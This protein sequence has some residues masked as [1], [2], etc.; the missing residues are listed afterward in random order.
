MNEALEALA[1]YEQEKWHEQHPISIH[2]D[3]RVAIDG[4]EASTPREIAMAWI[5]LRLHAQG[6]SLKAEGLALKAEIKTLKELKELKKT[7]KTP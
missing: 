4:I 3:A 1:T 5:I 2:R 7:Q 6:L